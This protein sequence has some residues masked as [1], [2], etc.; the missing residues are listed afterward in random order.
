MFSKT[1][2]IALAALA[3]ALIATGAQASPPDPEVITVRVSVAD[4]N[5]ASAPGASVALQRV[6][7]AAATICGDAPSAKELG[8]TMLY[9]ACLRSTVGHAVAS[10]GDPV[11]TAAYEG[12]SAR[13]PQVAS[14]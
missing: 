14:R 11:V 10:L 7:R 1:T 5:L 8:R 4:L 3:A 2:P 12:R 6:R 13:S 9:S